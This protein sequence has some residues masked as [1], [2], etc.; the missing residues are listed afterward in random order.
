MVENVKQTYTDFHLKKQSNHLYPT[1]WVIRTMLGTYPE[2]KYDRSKY[3]GG[4]ILDLG[5]GDG[6]NMPLLHNCGLDISGVEITQETVDMVTGAMSNMGIPTTLR[7]GD[8]ANIPFEDNI[9][10]YVLAC[11]SCYY[12]DKNG[13]FNDNLTEITRVLKPGGFLI[14]NFPAFTDLPI[15]NNFILNDTI[16]AEDGHVIITSDVFGIR[17]GYKFRPFR[18]VED[19]VQT[20]SPLYDDISTGY[21]FDNYYG[22]QQN[23]YIMTAKKK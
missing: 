23:L 8:N 20:F 13:T 3:K 2:L 12:I 21:T 9:F 18:S 22:L 14:A 10:D 1:E 5:F 4:K 15:P 6:R 17:N 7:V 11:A 16:P 19:I